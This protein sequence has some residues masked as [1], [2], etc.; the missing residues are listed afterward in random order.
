MKI[1]DIKFA[2]LTLALSLACFVSSSLPAEAEMYPVRGV[3]AA[4]NAE[5]PIAVD[6]ACLLIKTFGVEAL[7]SKSL[8]EMMIFTNDKRYDVKGNLQTESTLQ[9]SRAAEGG[10]WITELRT[11]RGRLWHRR[12]STFFLAI[13]DPVT[14]EIRDPSRRTRLVKCGPRGESHT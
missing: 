7:A 11:G 12:K 8:A 14:I 6:E 9:S 13:V 3:W 2:A 1:I 5:F 10:Y 4:P